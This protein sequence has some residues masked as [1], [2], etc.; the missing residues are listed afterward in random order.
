MDKMT[1]E[2]VF[3]YL[4]DLNSKE[5]KYIGILFSKGGEIDYVEKCNQ[6]LKD[7]KCNPLKEIVIKS[8]EDKVSKIIKD[9]CFTIENF[10][11]IN[12]YRL[13]KLYHEDIIKCSKEKPLVILEL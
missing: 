9:V 5:F 6:F 13:D 3:K 10:S 12:I 8:K 7:L 11:Y 4:D 2:E 1:Y